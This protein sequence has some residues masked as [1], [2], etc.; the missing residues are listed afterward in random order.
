MRPQVLG[1]LTLSALLGGTTAAAQGSKVKLDVAVRVFVTDSTGVPVDAAELSVVRG[2]KEVVA[3]GRTDAQG[4][5]TFL[6]A[7]DS[8]DYSIVARKPGYQRGDRFFAAERTSVDAPVVMKRIQGTL[9][10]VTVT[11]ADPKRHSYYIDADAIAAS[12]TY[13]HDALDVLNYLRPDMILS[14][15]GFLSGGGTCPPLRNI[16]V[17]GERY[18]ND[19]IVVDPLVRA[20]QRGAANRLSRIGSGNAT[21]LSEIAPEHISEMTYHDCFELAV[22]G[23]VG[24]VNALFIVLKPGVGY[25]PGVGSYVEVGEPVVAAKR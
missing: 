3:T 21:I 2:L 20:R 16:W 8:A 11:E 9:P 17:N 14:R 25:R 18:L 12:T 10:T 19:F 13:V 7:L 1:V 24:T 22:D 15:S 4:R 5:H 6:I 23:K